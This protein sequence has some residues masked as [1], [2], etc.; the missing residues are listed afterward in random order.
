M[1]RDHDF[2]LILA[3]SPGLSIRSSSL[4]SSPRHLSSIQTRQSARGNDSILVFTALDFFFAS[5]EDDFDM[6]RVTLVGID[7][8]VRTV[9]SAAGFL[10]VSKSHKINGIKRKRLISWRTGA[11]CTTMFLMNR[12]SSSK[13]FASALASA[14]LRRRVMNLTDFSGQRPMEEK[15]IQMKIR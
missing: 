4:N 10:S 12:F 5:T 3:H 7:T 2:S 6:A 8:T 1:P 15:K 14:F 9:C 11:C 13:D